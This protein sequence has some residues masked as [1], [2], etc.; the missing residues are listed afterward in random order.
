MVTSNK[1]TDNFTGVVTNGLGTDV[2]RQPPVAPNYYNLRSRRNIIKYQ[3]SS[4]S[5]VSVEFSLC[6]VQES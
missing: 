1:L 4:Q 5:N 3:R 2:V 6:L